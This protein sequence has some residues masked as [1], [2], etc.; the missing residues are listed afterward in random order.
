MT[1]HRVFH[2][3]RHSLA[4]PRSITVAG[5]AQ[6]LESRIKLTG[7]SK[8]FT[9]LN[10]LNPRSSILTYRTCFPIIPDRRSQPGHLEPRRRE[11]LRLAT[12]RDFNRP[13]VVITRM[14]CVYARI[15]VQRGNIRNLS[16]IH[17]SEPTRLL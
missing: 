13:R 12:T 14:A 7:L 11:F 1:A 16:L 15:R 3:V 5:A 8:S 2:Q 17:I 9:A 4:R 6:E 10:I